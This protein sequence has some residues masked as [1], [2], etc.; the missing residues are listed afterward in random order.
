M[1]EIKDFLLDLPRQCGRLELYRTFTR[2]PEKPMRHI[3]PNQ[4]NWHIHLVGILGSARPGDTIV[5]FSDSVREL[6]A[7]TRR[8]MCPDKF[9][10]FDVEEE[11]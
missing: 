8:R 3:I 1:I 5:C 11:A 2:T 4:A 9:L 10:I 6:A 7:Q